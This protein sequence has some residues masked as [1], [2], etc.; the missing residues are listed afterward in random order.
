MTTEP[1]KLE[2]KLTR[3]DNSSWLCRSVQWYHFRGGASGPFRQRHLRVSARFRARVEVER[4]GERSTVRRRRQRRL[5]RRVQTKNG[6][7][8]AALSE[9]NDSWISHEHGKSENCD[10][11]FWQRAMQLL[12]KTNRRRGL[13]IHFFV[14]EL[15]SVFHLQAKFALLLR[16]RRPKNVAQHIRP[17]HF[18]HAVRDGY[19]D[20]LGAV[21]S[22]SLSREVRM[23]YMLVFNWHL[24]F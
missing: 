8:Y 9:D 6:G 20:N 2:R 5:L 24:Y 22:S 3:S 17:E 16:T 15:S 4:T 23:M 7:H 1:P 19:H 18:E 12:R 11:V 10:D 14:A 21:A 13:W